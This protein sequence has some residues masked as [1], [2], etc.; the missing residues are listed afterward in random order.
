MPAPPRKFMQSQAWKKLQ[1]SS[2]PCPPHAGLPL[3]AV[4]LT[5]EE[6]AREMTILMTSSRRALGKTVSYQ[7]CPAQD[8]W[9][10]QT[11]YRRFNGYSLDADIGPR[12]GVT[13]GETLLRAERVHLSPSLQLP[14][15][16]CSRGPRG[17][18][19]DRE[20]HLSPCPSPSQVA[21]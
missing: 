15:K 14:Q 13:L 6:P 9:V 12:V 8:T 11:G 4:S 1:R 3:A 19:D 21:P 7:L 16:P 5:G 18:R 20:A 17:P 2:R 10:A